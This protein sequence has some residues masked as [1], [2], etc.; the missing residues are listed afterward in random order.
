M[1]LHACKKCTFMKGVD[2]T[3]LVPSLSADLNIHNKLLI[4]DNDQHIQLCNKHVDFKH[5]DIKHVGIKHFYINHIDFNHIDIEFKHVDL[6]HI[7]IEHIDIKHNYI[8]HIDFKHINIE[9]KHVDIEHVDIEHVDI[10]H[11]DIEHIDIEHMDIRGSWISPGPFSKLF[12]AKGLRS[13]CRLMFSLSHPVVY[14][15]WLRRHYVHI[16]HLDHGPLYNMTS[17]MVLGI[18]R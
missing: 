7:D 12:R 16:V 15:P 5:V 3:L 8:S 4:Y 17:L 1:I 9:F 10:E 2:F 6:K 14:P 18:T 13:P 11:V